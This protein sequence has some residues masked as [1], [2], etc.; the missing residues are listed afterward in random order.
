MDALEARAWL[1]VQR[2]VSQ[3]Q[4]LI[5]KPD[6]VLEY[7]CF[8]SFLNA[9][10]GGG[11]FSDGNQWATRG[12]AMAG[13]LSNPVGASVASYLQTNFNH[14]LLGGRSSINATTGGAVSAGGYSCSIM[15]Q[16]WDAARC[17]NFL[18]D[19]TA[20]GAD[21]FFDFP[22]YASTDPRIFPNSCTAGAGFM[23]GLYNQAMTAAFNNNQAQHTLSA[24][25]EK[26]AGAM[27]SAPLYEE[28]E[29]VTHL[30]MIL[31][32]PDCPGDPIPTGI[33]VNRPDYDPPTYDE[34]ICPN[35]GCSYNPS[36]DACEL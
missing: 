13:A 25:E 35:P 28:D 11:M 1:E 32:D 23:S 14:T 17:Y 20:M 27:F 6:S 9:T 30:D 19:S 18:N 36:T 3:N 21:G 22:K 29:V 33:V 26:A 12:N 5:V 2:E 16:V 24:A 34:K 7:T 8:G 10:A 31:P 15:Q 4:S